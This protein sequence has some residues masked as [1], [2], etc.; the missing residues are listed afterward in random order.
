MKEDPFFLAKNETFSWKK[1][2]PCGFQYSTFFKTQK[3]HFVSF[4]FNYWVNVLSVDKE[5][6][7]ILLLFF[8]EFNL[9]N[10]DIEENG[11]SHF[12]TETLGLHFSKEKKYKNIIKTLI[13]KY[14]KTLCTLIHVCSKKQNRRCL[15]GSLHCPSFKMFFY[16]M[17]GFE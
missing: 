17:F 12:L 13:W 15:N 2:R 6:K 11:R 9:Y 14:R 7:I 1:M 5:K 4:S 10:F 16:V 8:V 3:T